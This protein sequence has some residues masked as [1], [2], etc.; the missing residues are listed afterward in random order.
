MS[1]PAEIDLEFIRLNEENK[2]LRQALL[3]A[4][5]KVA[6]LID[7]QWLDAIAKQ[8]VRLTGKPWETRDGETPEEGRQANIG[9]IFVYIEDKAG[10]AKRL[11]A[12]AAA[13]KGGS[14]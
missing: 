11:E 10:E 5:E 13:K 6:G 2:V 3:E 4:E 1:D 8:W 12:E 14:E 7:E 9:A